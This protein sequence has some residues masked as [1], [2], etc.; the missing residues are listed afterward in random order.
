MA[1]INCTVDTV[2]NIECRVERA[3]TVVDSNYELLKNKPSINGNELVG[4]KSF[5]DLGLIFD[6]KTIVKADGK[7][8][9]ADGSHGHTIENVEGLREELDGMTA[10]VSDTDNPHNVTKEQVGLGKVENKSSEDIRGELTRNDV[11][12]A[13]GYTPLSSDGAAETVSSTV[14]RQMRPSDHFRLY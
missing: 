10:H 13:L 3:K 4:D 2:K 8:T 11:I 1:E 5:E 14:L 6:D 9:V 7:L 12:G